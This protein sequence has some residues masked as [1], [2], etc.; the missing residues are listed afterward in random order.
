MSQMDVTRREFTKSLA[1]LGAAAG[2]SN[3]EVPD[4][5][6]DAGSGGGTVSW[7]MIGTGTRGLELLRPLS[8]TTLGRCVALCDNYPVNLKKGLETIGGNPAS[9]DD[10]RRVLERKDVDT[11]LIATPLYLHASMVLDALS[12]GKHVFVEK[13]MV[14]KEDEVKRV[15]E[16]A[17]A[18][19]KQVLQ[20]GLQRRYSLIY[21]AAMEMIRKEALGKVTHVCAHWNRN[22]NWRRP[23]TDP[24]MERH[25]NWR[26]YREYSG[27]L[28]AE[29]G[30]H[31]IDIASW[32]FDAEPQAVMGAGGIDYWKDG[33]EVY[34]NVQCLFEYPGGR[35]LIYHSMLNNVHYQFCERILGDQ[36]TMELTLMG[37]SGT[38]TFWFEPKAKVSAAGAKE[39]WWAGATVVADA[40]QKGLPLF[41]DH[42]PSDQ[43]FLQREMSYA[44]RWLAHKGWYDLTEP[45][46]PVGVQ[47]EHFLHCVRDGRKP[48]ADVNVG[49]ADSLGVIYS[50]RAMDENRRVTWS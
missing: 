2:L 20:V 17:A 8:K 14:F 21:R 27:G 37:P 32:A 33:R 34:D 9:T 46:D 45:Q 44:K 16:A 3:L 18:H 30:S 24:K 13:S 39:Q 12:A 41:P 35:K 31:Q 28:M 36:G 10:Y 47:L 50:N 4:L 26:M 6:A 25:I 15:R 7:A 43:S 22:N 11:V 40:Q 48:L 29:L 38:G 1:A 19:P 23:V 42:S 5:L 49:A